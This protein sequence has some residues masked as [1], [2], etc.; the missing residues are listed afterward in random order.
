[1]GTENQELEQYLEALDEAVPKFPITI[2]TYIEDILGSSYEDRTNWTEH[3]TR[4]YCFDLH[5][6][7]HFLRREINKLHVKMNFA[8]KQVRIMH[9]KYARSKYAT[10][11]FT[12]WEECTAIMEAD[13]STC[14]DFL[15]MIFEAKSEIQS[16][17][18][19]A[20]MCSTLAEDLKGLAYTKKG[21]I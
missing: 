20:D 15:T 14:Q 18:L 9:G 19:E 3:K 16:L 6:Y 1:M 7:E 17:K 2:P 13:N 4:Q 21:H 11:N 12:K 10:S 5:K 8:N